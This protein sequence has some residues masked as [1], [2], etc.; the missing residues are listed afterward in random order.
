MNNV[1]KVIAL[2]VVITSFATVLPMKRKKPLF[3][4]S[5]HIDFNEKMD[6]HCNSKY[7]DDISINKCR[8]AFL[9]QLD[10][11]LFV[12]ATNKF[13]ENNNLNLEKFKYVSQENVEEFSEIVEKG[14]R[15]YAKMEDPKVREYVKKCVMFECKFIKSKLPLIRELKETEAELKK[16]YEELKEAEV[17]LEKI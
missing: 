13:Q 3:R 2:S 11:L 9:N 16:T 8:E 7:K 1:K 17:E 10:L 4:F 14:N 6:K 15:A 12:A 5:H